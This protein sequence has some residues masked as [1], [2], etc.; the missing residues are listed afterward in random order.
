MDREIYLFR[1]RIRKLSFHLRILEMRRSARW[2]LDRFGFG[3]GRLTRFAAALVVAAVFFLAILGASAFAGW[4]SRAAFGI[5]AS[6]LATAFVI[7][8]FLILG[9]ADAALESERAEIRTELE[10]TERHV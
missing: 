3:N 1:R 2:M 9:P 5:G 4:Q 10:D 8:T 7:G 6:A